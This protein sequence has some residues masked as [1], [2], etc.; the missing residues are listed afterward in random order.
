MC[1]MLQLLEK[2]QLYIMHAFLNGLKFQDIAG[3]TKSE[4]VVPNLEAFVNIYEL[5]VADSVI[6]PHFME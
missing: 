4:F 2:M 5:V 3:E 1:K 6:T